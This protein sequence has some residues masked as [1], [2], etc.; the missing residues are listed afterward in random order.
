M[1]I[2]YVKYLQDLRATV[3]RI[4]SFIILLKKMKMV[5]RIFVYHNVG[6]ISKPYFVLLYACDLSFF[7]VVLCPCSSQL[8][9]TPLCI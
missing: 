1:V 4:S 9:A 5:Y 7:D 3:I 6:P 8:L 2:S